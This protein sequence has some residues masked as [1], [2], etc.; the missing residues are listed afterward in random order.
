MSLRHP[1]LRDTSFILGHE[2]LCAHID[3]CIN[4]SDKRK[5]REHVRT[6]IHTHS[7]LQCVAVGCS[8]SQCVAV[9]CGVLQRAAV[10]WSARVTCCNDTL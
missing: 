1:V 6:Y 5:C 10:C 7:M 4:S 9:C 3:T 2:N 8:V